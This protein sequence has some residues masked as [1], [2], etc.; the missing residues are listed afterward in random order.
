MLMKLSTL[1]ICIIVTYFVSVLGIG[2]FLKR[3]IHTS[4][5]FLLS[6]RS[7]SHWVTG[8]AFMSA[9]LGSLEVM[10]H[11]A[12]GAKYGMRTN[13]FFWI[14]AVPAMLFCGLFM[15]RF[16]YASGI[17]SVAEYLRLRFDYRAHLMNAVSFAFVT[18]LMSGINMFAFAIVFKAM[19]GWPFTASI[20]LSA[21]IVLLYTF[22]GGLTSSIY[23]EVVQFFLILIGFLPLSF[24]V[25]RDMGGWSGLVARLPSQFTHTWQ[26]MGG[27]KDPLGVDWWVVVLGLALTA[28]PSYW[29]CD[30]LLI[31]RA[32]AA[33][34]L[35]SARKTPILAAIPKMAMPAIVTV[36]GMAARVEAP[37]V[38]LQDYNLALPELLGHYYHGGMLGLGLTALLASFMSGMAGN[39]TAFNTVFT[40]DIY[41]T[42]LVKNR[43]DKHY[44]NVGRWATVW[45]T[46]LGCLSAYI[47]LYFNNLM[48]Y[49]QLI[50]VLFIAPFFI[51]FLLGMFWKRASATAGF[52]GLLAGTLGSFAEYILYQTHVL[53]FKSPMASN[54]W[55]AVWGMTAGLIVMVVASFC[56]KPPRMENLRGLTYSYRARIERAG[57]WYHTPEAYAVVVLA[58][59]IYLNVKFF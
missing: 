55:T 56:T 15:I 23:N 13:H 10:G 26:G 6:H 28:G 42:Y 47:A 19:L 12:N 14:G 22:W 30:F 17:R 36:L 53:H 7:L 54:I 18:V 35:D 43:P 44:L 39:V 11:I 40:Y 50:G 57:K 41:Q 2:Y 1:D 51:V 24:F 16:Y 45:G 59:L 5:D 29:C 38:V 58:I 27:P 21:G 4:S 32:L 20:L 3:G 34:N 9:N 48:D 31:Q 49:M 8:I 52:Y 25:L 37:K 46:L 33:K